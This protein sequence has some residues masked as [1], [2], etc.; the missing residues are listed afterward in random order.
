MTKAMKRVVWMSVAVVALVGAY[1]AVSVTRA[2]GPRVAVVPAKPAV[3]GVERIVS[4]QPFLLERGWRH[5]WRAEQPLF[6]AGWIVVLEVDPA[7]VVPRQVAEPVLYAGGETV[8]RV[9]F[10]HGSG[11]VVAIIPSARDAQGGV[12]VDL[13]VTP[14]WFGA[15][16]LPERVDGVRVAEEMARAVA[17][18]VRPL[19]A[20][21]V[22]GEALR[23]RSRDELDERAAVM[24]LENAPDEGDLGLGMLAPRVGQK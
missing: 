7:L 12:A 10:G 6:D 2:G 1:S 18:G 8:E 9:N 23:L 3:G 5:T 24:V 19:V 15:A 16:E 17:K 11:R 20:P 4:A 21:V 14:L 13:S 22:V